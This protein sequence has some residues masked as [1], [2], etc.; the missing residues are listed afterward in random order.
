MDGQGSIRWKRSFLRLDPKALR[1]EV[2]FSLRKKLRFYF[3]S[4][5]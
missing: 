3:L 1:G 5:F 4:G 2:D